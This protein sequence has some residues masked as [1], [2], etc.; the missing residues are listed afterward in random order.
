MPKPNKMRNIKNILFAVLL[1]PPFTFSLAAQRNVK[2]ETIQS[3]GSFS[4]SL[5]SSPAFAEIVLRQTE[6]RAD[7]ESLL[8][9]YTEEFPKVGEL[10]FEID[11]LGRETQRLAAVKTADNSKLTLALGK[12]LVRKAELET[13]LWSLQRSYNAEYPDVK[14]AKRKVEIYENAIKEILN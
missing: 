2:V 14:R 5:K 12:L 6:L 11:A 9:S 1:I 8:I 13:D 7:L 4:Q 3:A 10:R